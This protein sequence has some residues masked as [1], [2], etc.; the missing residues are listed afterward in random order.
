MVLSVRAAIQQLFAISFFGVSFLG[1]RLRAFLSEVRLDFVTF[2]PFFLV[3][4]HAVYHRRLAP[5][6]R[7][8]PH[9]APSQSER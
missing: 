3:A 4:I 9:V 1:A 2:L 8:L 5:F 7:R 6:G